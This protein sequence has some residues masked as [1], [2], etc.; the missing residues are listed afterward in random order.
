MNRFAYA[1]HTLLCMCLKDS[2]NEKHAVILGSGSTDA[3]LS[4][5]A[6]APNGQYSITAASQNRPLSLLQAAAT[7]HQAFT[8]TRGPD[9]AATCGHDSMR[10]PENMGKLPPVSRCFSQHGLPSPQI[11]IMASHTRSASIYHVS[12]HRAAG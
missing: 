1:G 11:E 2:E 5:M 9:C 4:S 6:A 7:G 3:V 10:R 8:W 12:L